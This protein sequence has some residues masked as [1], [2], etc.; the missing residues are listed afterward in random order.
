MGRLVIDRTGHSYRHGS[1]GRLVIDWVKS[2]KGIKTPDFTCGSQEISLKNNK[3]ATVMTCITDK[4][5]DSLLVLG[6]A[7]ALSPRQLGNNGMEFLE[8]WK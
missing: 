8:A 2:A 1:C 5:Y 3:K 7:N 6:T 4:K